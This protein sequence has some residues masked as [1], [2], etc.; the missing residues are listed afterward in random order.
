M[1]SREVGIVFD[2]T[3]LPGNYSVMRLDLS[4]GLNIALCKNLSFYNV[5]VGSLT[6]CSVHRTHTSYKSNTHVQKG[7]LFCLEDQ[8]NQTKPLF[9]ITI[10]PT[11]PSLWIEVMMQFFQS[12]SGS[13]IVSRVINLTLVVLQGEM[14]LA[15]GL[16]KL[17]IPFATTVIVYGFA[18]GN[19]NFPI[20]Q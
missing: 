14:C 1:L 18:I 6:R 19:R 3:C 16:Y 11:F 4:R 20:L 5:Q 15:I 12:T 10:N 8:P 7:T 9:Q 13:C 2:W 17:V